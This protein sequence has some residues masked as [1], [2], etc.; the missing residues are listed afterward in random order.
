MSLFLSF[1]LVFFIIK[2]YSLKSTVR[3]SNYG[4]GPRTW[5]VKDCRGTVLGRG[6]LDL[7]I[8]GFRG[9]DLC[10][11]GFFSGWA[12]CETGPFIWIH[13]FFLHVLFYLKK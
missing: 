5:P 2:S 9:T 12:F 10:R 3:D 1:F 11:T 6:F 7:Q 8:Y 4:S 13:I